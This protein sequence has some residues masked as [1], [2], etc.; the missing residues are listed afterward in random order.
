MAMAQFPAA[1]PQPG[2]GRD[3]RPPPSRHVTQKFSGYPPCGE[4]ADGG[5]AI[6]EMEPNAELQPGDLLRAGRYEIKKLLRF[7]RDKDI[8]L[9]QN[10]A[11]AC[12]VVI[13]VFSNNNSILP[14]GLTVS[15][16]EAQV[17]RSAGRSSKHRDSR[18]LLGRRQDGDHGHPLSIWRDPARSY[19]AGDRRRP[20]SSE[21]PAA[22][23]GDRSRA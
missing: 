8:Y 21:D 16:W 2:R 12:P 14:N 22:F 18:R 9:A 19:F 7:T 20:A 11:L 6:M 10:R 13:D 1:A 5:P 23:Y 17:L 4:A 15:A 3:R